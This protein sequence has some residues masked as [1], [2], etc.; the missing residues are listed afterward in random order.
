MCCFSIYKTLGTYPL[1][2]GG[3]L[4]QIGEGRVIKFYVSTKGTLGRAI[5]FLLNIA[6]HL[7]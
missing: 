7:K 1:L 6:E 4:M 3:R 2:E 5:P